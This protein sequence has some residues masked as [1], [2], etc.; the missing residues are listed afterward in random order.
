MRIPAGGSALTEPQDGPQGIEERMYERSTW[1]NDDLGADMID[2]FLTVILPAQWSYGRRT[3]SLQSP[4]KR[5]MLAVL[6]DAVA[7]LARNAAEQTEGERDAVAEV[8]G[9]CA[10]EDRSWPFSFTNICEALGF[11]P[12]CVRSAL[13]RLKAA[14]PDAGK[15]DRSYCMRRPTGTRTR[16]V[17]PR[18]LPR[19]ALAS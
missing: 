12:S 6:E 9:W 5:L 11:D 14:T 19:A 17:A 15:H 1:P 4:E 18:H 13:G 3:D 8:E 10:S 16:V 2:P 7:S